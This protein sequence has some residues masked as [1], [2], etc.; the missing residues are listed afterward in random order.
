MRGRGRL[1]PGVY[2]G[3][4]P[5]PNPRSRKAQRCERANSPNR[6]KALTWRLRGLNLEVSMSR[7]PNASKS[8]FAFVARIAMR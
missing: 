1:L 5:Q 2:L 7:T 4:R 6:R 3:A 8:I